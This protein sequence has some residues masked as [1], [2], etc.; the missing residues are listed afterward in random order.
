MSE[1]ANKAMDKIRDEMAKTKND[2]VLEIGEAMTELL[3]IAPE[4]SEQILAEGKTCAGAYKV[5]ESYARSN[6]KTCVPP[7][8]ATELVAEYWGLPLEQM[9]RAVMG[10][11]P[12]E[13]TANPSGASRHLPY[14][15]EAV[16]GGGAGAG[17]NAGSL[18]D[19][20]DAL[21]GGL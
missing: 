4:L 21:L 8:K 18:L 14:R 9:R 16:M 17:E 5:V 20:F 13:H 15:G 12:Q 1:M 7:R 11:E 19:D 10:A 2:A 3:L 6:Y